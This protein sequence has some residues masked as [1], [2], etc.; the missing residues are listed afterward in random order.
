MVEVVRAASSSS[1][2]FVASAPAK[3]IMFGE[4]SVV[5]GHMAIASAIDLRTYFDV[6]V[7][8]CDYPDNDFIFLEFEGIWPNGIK[9]NRI[10]LQNGCESS[11]E[12]ILLAANN[13]TQKCL[14]DNN[15]NSPSTLLT[16]ALCMCIVIFI[17]ASSKSVNGSVPPLHNRNFFVSIK[18]SSEVPIASGLGSSASFSVAGVVACLTLNGFIDPYSWTPSEQ[19]FVQ[20][21]KLAN[22]AEMVAHGKP[23]GLDASICTRGG[24]ITFKMGSPPICEPLIHPLDSSSKILIVNSGIERSTKDAV[25]FVLDKYRQDH[26]GIERIFSDIDTIAHSACRIMSELDFKTSNQF[27]KELMDLV[28]NGHDLLKQLGVSH[29]TLDHIVRIASEFNVSAK[30][31][32]A[33]WGGCV[34]GLFQE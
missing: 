30:L 17:K 25:E 32:G 1:M 34:F 26:E 19:E 29:P 18:V 22:L 27:T 4:H 16:V 6:S 10:H 24:A 11:D 15:I 3:V 7:K 8:S 13:C 14:S 33:G 5:Y 28:S 31:T 23:S 20:I 12:E 9:V 2:R 21:A